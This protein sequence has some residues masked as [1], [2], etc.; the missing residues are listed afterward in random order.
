[1]RKKI[2][3][4]IEQGIPNQLFDEEGERISKKDIANKIYDKIS[5]IE[6]L[7]LLPFEK[8][9]PFICSNCYYND[10]HKLGCSYEMYSDTVHMEKQPPEKCPFGFDKG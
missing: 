6:R 8:W 10:A 5:G 1:M 4:I 7:D 2:I 3:K 9:I